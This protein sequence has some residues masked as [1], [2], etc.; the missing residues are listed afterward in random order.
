MYLK[1]TSTT[2]SVVINTARGKVGIKPQEVADIKY[3]I[4]P[5]VSKSIQ[6]ISEEEYFSF[7]EKRKGTTEAIIEVKEKDIDKPSIVVEEERL[8]DLER[9]EDEVVE[10]DIKNPSIMS[11]V[12][13]LIEPKPEIKD[14]ENEA[15]V[16]TDTDSADESAELEQQIADLKNSWTATKSPRKKEKIA[17]EIK[18]LQKQLKKIKK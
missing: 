1:N 13:S 15:L 10:T 11:F 3:K 14:K 4:L 7:C 6:Q 12:N 5:P 17:K 16:V 8:D 9:T 18:E 2:K